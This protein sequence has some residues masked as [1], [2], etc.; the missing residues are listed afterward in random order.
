MDGRQ[1]F[2]TRFDSWTK[3]NF[4]I[5]V[6]VFVALLASSIITIISSVSSAGDWYTRTFNWRENEY[7]KL[8]GL[9]AGF[10]MEKFK[11]TLGDPLYRAKVSNTGRKLIESVFPG[12]GYWVDVLSDDSDVVLAYSVT[13]CNRQ[14]QPT[15]RPNMNPSSPITL[16][17]T[18][19]ADI[20]VNSDADTT[21]FLSGATA[22]SYIYQSIYQG[23]PSN[24]KTHA[25]GLN[26]ACQWFSTKDSKGL[27]GRWLTWNASEEGGKFTKN[28][29]IGPEMRKLLAISAVNTYMET[30]PNAVDIST[31]E[32]GIKELYP[33]QLGVDRIIVRSYPGQDLVPWTTCDVASDC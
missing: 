32:H 4:T 26:D 1:S 8:T 11:S 17:K 23:N 16:N 24:Y 7:R 29:S 5:V 10:S 14:F 25:W 21:V 28:K 31:D 30:A 20:P 27:G 9:Q 15:F 13:S 12:R 6:I 18:T 2:G 3:R 33:Q 19:F 22:N